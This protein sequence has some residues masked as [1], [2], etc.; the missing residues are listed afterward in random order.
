MEIKV[1]TGLPD[2]RTRNK[3]RLSADLSDS[4]ENVRV[5]LKLQLELLPLLFA[6]FGGRGAASVI[7]FFQFS[8]GFG[9]GLA[10]DRFGPLQRQKLRFQRDREL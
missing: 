8:L 4:R 1:G 7:G 5:R 6:G 9:H 3:K 2:G 10:P